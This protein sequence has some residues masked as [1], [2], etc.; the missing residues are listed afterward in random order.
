MR[1]IIGQRT[2]PYALV[3]VMLLGMGGVAALPAFG[4]EP[5]WEITDAEGDLFV[6][7]ADGVDWRMAAPSDVLTRGDR[8]WAA[9]TGR[10][11]VRGPEGRI[12]R[13]DHQTQIELVQSAASRPTLSLLNGAVY[14]KHPALGRNGM[15]FDLEVGRALLR[16]EGP[17]MAR[18][19]MLEDNAVAVAVHKGEVRI[20]TDADSTWIGAGEM[21]EVTPTAMIWLPE[22]IRLAHRDDFDDWNEEMELRLARRESRL[23]AAES[24]LARLDG[25]GEWVQVN[26]Y[27]RVWR[28]QVA[29]DWQPYFYGQW[30]WVSSFGWSWVSA[31]PWGWLPSHYG[32]WVWDGFYGWVWIP[33]YTWAPAWVIWTPYGAG[34][35]WAPYGP[36]V[37]PVSIAWRYWCWTVDVGRAG[38]EHHRPVGPVP[39]VHHRNNIESPG[40]RKLQPPHRADGDRARND[41]VAGIKPVHV[42][43]KKT[44]FQRTDRRD[45]TLNRFATAERPN[46]RETDLAPFHREDPGRGLHEAPEQALRERQ[47]RAVRSTGERRDSVA[48]ERGSPTGQFDRS[49]RQSPA[50]AEN[51]PS[52][53]LPPPTQAVAPQ[54][55]RGTHEAEVPAVR[56][57]PRTTEARRALPFPAPSPDSS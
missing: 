53:P 38:W 18:V 29:L 45:E 7:P 8:L 4:G 19:E 54:W 30:V 37:I 34:W 28:P 44:V 48:P 56:G 24:G 55:R 32:Q 51:A 22:N 50:S 41:Q 39:P 31:E 14:L 35:A 17:T 40:S 13:L 10:A 36:F 15:E 5:T 42:E 1:R 21:T 33:G 16:S 25:Y 52:V 43:R 6:L 57:E 46:S 27:G 47:E 20:V 26:T 3:V 12:V 9:P 2:G 23:D 49:P 11:V